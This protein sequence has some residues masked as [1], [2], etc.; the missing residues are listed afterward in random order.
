MKGLIYIA[1]LFTGFSFGQAEVGRLFEEL[2]SD[3]LIVRSAQTHT[4][5]KPAIRQA[6]FTKNYVRFSAS[7]RIWQPEVPQNSTGLLRL[8][9]D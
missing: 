2:P 1:L 5:L 7:P 9:Q 3:S 8:E 4:S 6:N